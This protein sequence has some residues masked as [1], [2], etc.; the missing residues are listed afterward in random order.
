MPPDREKEQSRK[1]FDT[2]ISKRNLRA[3]IRALPTQYQPGKEREIMVPWDRIFAAGT[4]GA[5]RF[6]DRHITRHP[7]YADVEKGADAR[8]EHEGKDREENVV[9]ERHG[10]ESG[11]AWQNWKVEK[12]L[13]PQSDISIV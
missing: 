13:T 12:C 5:L 1:R 2:E 11:S 7:V 6:A 4:K 9:S 10:R 3:A 8:T